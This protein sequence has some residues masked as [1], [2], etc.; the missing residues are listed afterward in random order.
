MKKTILAILLATAT[1]VGMSA[2]T[3]QLYTKNGITVLINADEAGEMIVSGGQISV[4]REVFDISS[5]DSMTYVST[6]FDPQLVEIGYNGNQSNVRVPLALLPLLTIEKDG[7]YVT[8]T[9]TATA[10]PE[11]TYS[12]SGITNDGGLTLVGS[13]KCGLILNGVNI[14]S[15]RG[16]AIHVDNGKRIDVI[17][18]EGTV[19]RLED[20]AGGLQSACFHIKGHPEFKGAGSLYLTGNTRHAFKSGEYTY[21]KPSTGLISIQSAVSDAMH[22]GQYFQMRGGTIEIGNGVMG[23]G[24]QVEKDTDPLKENNGMMFL[25]SGKV[26]INLASDDV[27][28]IKC[29]STFYCNGGEYTVLVSG[30]NSKGINIPYDGHI[31]ALNGSP[32]FDLTASGGYLEVP[33]PGSNKTDKKKSTCF[34]VDGNLYFHAGTIRT[35]ASGD[36]ARGLKTEYDFHYVPDKAILEP[37]DISNVGGATRIMAE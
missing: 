12:A 4:G 17:M 37:F 19:N 20:S 16:V 31:K 34:K 13:Y 6:N 29:D 30:K 10:D 2:Q 27:S 18:T 21:L 33:I 8:L 15:L 22:V 28:G 23:D 14:K 36:K 1:M 9:S 3:L 11:I 24:I 5:L 7:A 26:N 32:L 25:D 35:D